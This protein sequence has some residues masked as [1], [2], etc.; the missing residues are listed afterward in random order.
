MCILSLWCVVPVK[1][2]PRCI[3]FPQA[4]VMLAFSMLARHSSSCWFH[5]Y[6]SLTYD[7]IRLRAAWLYSSAPPP[8][9]PRIDSLS[10][11]GLLF[12]CSTTSTL[13]SSAHPTSFPV[14]SSP[15]LSPPYTGVLVL[16]LFRTPFPWSSCL[17]FCHISL[18]TLSSNSSTRSAFRIQFSIIC[19]RRFEIY[20]RDANCSEVFRFLHPLPILR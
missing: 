11:R 7:E 2:P 19:Q 10:P 9:P 17:L 12:Q 4:L 14:P 3:R 8:P 20:G 13:T 5:V 6:L 1:Y 16:P 18:Q 15:H